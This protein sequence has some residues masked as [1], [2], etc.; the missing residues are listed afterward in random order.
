VLLNLS[1]SLLPTLL[2]HPFRCG[3]AVKCVVLPK[4]E[5]G[6]RVLNNWNFQRS[7]KRPVGY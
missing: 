2:S 1:L 5:K 4:A 3:P 6:R 7:S